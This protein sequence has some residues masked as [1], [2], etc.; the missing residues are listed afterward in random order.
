M[1]QRT[2]QCTSQRAAKCTVQYTMQC[3]SHHITH[4]L[5]VIA[6]PSRPKQIAAAGSTPCA[7][8][9]LHTSAPNTSMPHTSTPAHTQVALF[10]LGELRGAVTAAAVTA[11]P[12]RMPATAA[13]R[14]T[15]GAGCYSTGV[16]TG[17]DK[18]V[19]TG[20]D[21]GMDTTSHTQDPGHMAAAANVRGGNERDRGGDRDR[22]GC[23]DGG[24]AGACAGEC[25]LG[26]RASDV[27]AAE[28][29]GC[30]ALLQA[31]ATR[32]A[33]TA[34]GADLRT[35]FGWL[36]R[37]WCVLEGQPKVGRGKGAPRD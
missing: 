22:G 7:S 21:T 23:D 30:Q 25:A 19:R 6:H 33:V 16:G 5:S 13:R 20:M 12:P 37:V 9:C 2:L 29:A 17:E 3:T 35:F 4:T 32:L 24:G 11:A 8:T 26:I 15:P 36:H 28:L 34:A 1:E 27:A 31:E 18:G 10:L 14:P